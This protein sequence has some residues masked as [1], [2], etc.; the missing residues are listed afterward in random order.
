MDETHALAPYSF[1]IDSAVAEWLHQAATTG[2]AR[3]A[4]EYERTIRS[5]R[6]FLARAG[7]DLLPIRAQTQEAITRHAI[8]LAR[9]AAHMPATCA[10]ARIKNDGT[11]SQRFKQDSP[12]SANTYNLRLAALSSFYSFVQDTYK[13]SIPNPVNAQSVKRRQVQ[14]YADAATQTIL[15]DEVERALDAIDRSTAEGLRDY[16][17]IAIAVYTG[18]RASWP[19]C[20]ARVSRW[21]DAASGFKFN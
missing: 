13:L 15:P 1:T 14:L 8:D 7:L 21:W 17:L 12:V 6:Q 16:A 10:P 11:K 18:R 2:S 9:V 20:A 19:A 5:F 4:I 3:T